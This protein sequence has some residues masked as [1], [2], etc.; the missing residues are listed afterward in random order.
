MRVVDVVAEDE[1][2]SGR[3]IAETP[4]QRSG[5]RLR[6][7]ALVN[8]ITRRR[9]RF[10]A[11]LA[12]LSRGLPSRWTPTLRR[13]ADRGRDLPCRSGNSRTTRGP[14]AV[15]ASV[16]RDGSAGHSPH[17]RDTR[18]ELDLPRP[19]RTSRGTPRG[20]TWAHFTA[21]RIGRGRPT[22][23]RRAL[24][25]RRRDPPE[26]AARTDGAPRPSLPTMLCPS[27]RWTRPRPHHAYTTSIVERVG[28]PR[29][30]S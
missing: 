5:E 23:G 14:R 4:P 8:S 7:L 10:S 6:A 13:G 18:V 29:S 20:C 1:A 2:G 26:R 3:E 17:P 22:S 12:R 24:R 21:P 16:R 27:T 28:H 30:N 19:A 15:L 11:L 9:W 25:F